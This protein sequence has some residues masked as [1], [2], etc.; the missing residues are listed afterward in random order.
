MKTRKFLTLLTLPLILTS[1]FRDFLV[2]VDLYFLGKNK[3]QDFVENY[4]ADSDSLYV[5]EL[6][7]FKRGKN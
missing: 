4:I 1:C 2:A 3:F 5:R 6:Y 7:L